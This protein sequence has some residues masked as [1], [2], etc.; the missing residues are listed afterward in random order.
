MLSTEDG[1]F[2][3]ERRRQLKFVLR[4]GT[5]F[6]VCETFVSLKTYNVYSLL[7]LTGIMLNLVLRRGTP[8]V[9]TFSEEFLKYV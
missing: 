6:C 8:L 2:C 3:S 5:N 7:Y 4:D 1:S 9:F